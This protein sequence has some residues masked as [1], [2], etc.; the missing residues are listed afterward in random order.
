[1]KTISLEVGD[2]L[3]DRFHKMS[4]VKKAAILK[5]LIEGIT[6]IDSL[7]DLL[8]FNNRLAEQQSISE[9]KLAELLKK[10]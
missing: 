9:K 6:S 4:T 2:E 10:A 8:N 1:M 5:I 7:N 3:A